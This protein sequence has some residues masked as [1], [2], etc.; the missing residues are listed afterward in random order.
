MTVTRAPAPKMAYGVDDR[1]HR[2]QHMPPVQEPSA[3]GTAGDRQDG[4]A[5]ACLSCSGVVTGAW[6][7]NWRHT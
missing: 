6:Q 4:L 2:L 1:V 3:A 5:S 7:V